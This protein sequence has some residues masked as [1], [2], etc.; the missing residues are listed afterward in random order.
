[1]LYSVADLEI[2]IW[3][4]KSKIKGQNSADVFFFRKSLELLN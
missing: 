3:D 4:Q 1:M 2:G